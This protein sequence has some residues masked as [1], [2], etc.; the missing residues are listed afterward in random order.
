MMVT[1]VRIDGPA[2]DHMNKKLIKKHKII[3]AENNF[4]KI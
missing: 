1:S 4:P 2:D 3:K